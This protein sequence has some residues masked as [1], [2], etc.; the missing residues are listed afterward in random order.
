MTDERFN[1][2]D[3]KLDTIIEHQTDVRVRLERINFLVE[4][5]TCDLSEHIRRTNLLEMKTGKL[6]KRV[7]R[8]EEPRRVLNYLKARWKSHLGILTLI[9]VIIGICVGLKKLGL[10]D[11]FLN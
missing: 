7:D 3:T 2:L 8:L 11:L 5:N 6:E 9:S 1:H 10:L 4:K